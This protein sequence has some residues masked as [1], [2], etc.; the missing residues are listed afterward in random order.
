MNSRERIISTLNHKEPDRIPKDLGSTDSSGI[1]WIAYNNLKKELGISGNTRVFDLMQMIVKVEEKVLKIVGSDA[2]SLISEP[3]EWK[4]F[5]FIKGHPIEIPEKVQIEEKDD[6]EML[7]YSRDGKPSYKRP[8]GGFYFDSIYHPFKDADS[9][10]DIDRGFSFM[11][12]YD[13]PYYMDESLDD[14]KKRAVALH[15]KTDYAVVANLWVHLL[16]SGQDLRGF[17]NFMMDLLINKK[18]AHRFLEKQVEAYIPRIDKYLEAVGNY[19]DVV[20]VNDDLGTQNGLQLSR[21]LYIEMLKPYHKK[22]WQY[23]KQKSKKHILLHSCGSIYELIP[24]LIEMGVDAINPVQVS[25]KNMDSK[26]LK[27]EFGKDITF[28]GGGCDTQKVLPYGT[29]KDVK[30]EVKRRVNDLASGGGFVFCQVHNIQPDVPVENIIA[31]YKTLNE[32]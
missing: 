29:E 32:F 31:M 22:L 28:W 14:L 10:E 30:E 25:A 26:K 9:L 4:T 27:T 5:E 21:E 2:V 19:I 15:E 6:G 13:M 20:Q 16:A 17:E 11:Q 1:T 18:M 23:I 12:S 3:R 8:K 7:I 24:D